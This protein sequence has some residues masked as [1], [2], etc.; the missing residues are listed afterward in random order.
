[1]KKYLLIGI[2]FVL[3]A[4][5]LVGALTYHAHAN[6][7]GNIGCQSLAGCRGA[8]RCESPGSASGCSIACNNG[9][10]IQC[11]GE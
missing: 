4:F 7:G 9:A 1:M 6:L 3:S 5:N 10:S 2:V 11:P 8:A